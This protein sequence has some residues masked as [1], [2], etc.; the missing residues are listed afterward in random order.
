MS[1]C[2]YCHQPARA[3]CDACTDIDRQVRRRAEQILGPASV[4]AAEALYGS[5]GLYLLRLAGLYHQTGLKPHSNQ[6]RQTFRADERPAL[7][8]GVWSWN[9]HAIHTRVDHPV[10]MRHEHGG[11]GVLSQV[12]GERHGEGW[13]WP[14]ESPFGHGT[15][16][17]LFLSP[18]ARR[19]VEAWIDNDQTAATDK[20]TEN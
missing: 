20:G 14:G 13:A 7:P 8:T 5:S 17:E 1:E 18:V 6:Y 3:V 12:Y 19:N 2:H 15:R 16:A 4:R 9:P 11:F 10:L